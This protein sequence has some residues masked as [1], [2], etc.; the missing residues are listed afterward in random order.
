MVKC[1]LFRRDFF[2]NFFGIA[3]RYACLR[4]HFF[5]WFILFLNS[6]NWYNK[7]GWVEN[8]HW[9]LAANAYAIWNVNVN[10]NA[11]VNVNVCLWFF[12]LYLACCG[13]TFPGSCALLAVIWK[14]SIA[15]DS[16][17]SALLQLAVN[18]IGREKKENMILLIKCHWKSQ[19][20]MVITTATRFARIELHKYMK[21]LL[22]PK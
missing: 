20:Q 6:Q 15:P 8:A 17:P 11:I 2:V 14:S 7:F 1:I 5:F 19:Q 13:P 18:K 4:C 12:V 3:L 22:T 21:N 16:M 9:C 10:A